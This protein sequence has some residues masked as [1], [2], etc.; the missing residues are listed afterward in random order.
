M[1][2]IWNR[3]KHITCQIHPFLELYKLQSRLREKSL[4]L[5]VHVMS[6][7]LN[8]EPQRQKP[9]DGQVP[10]PALCI[11]SLLAAQLDDIRP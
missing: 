6:K 4:H 3:P 10:I 7:A 8:Q 1:K 5:A 9:R 11:H 2:K